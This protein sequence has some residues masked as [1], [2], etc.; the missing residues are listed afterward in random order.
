MWLIE[1][2]WRLIFKAIA[3]VSQPGDSDPFLRDPYEVWSRNESYNEDIPEARVL[4]NKCNFRGHYKNSFA[5][6]W[7]TRNIE[8]VLNTENRW[9]AIKAT[10]YYNRVKTLLSKRVKLNSFKEFN[11]RQLVFELSSIQLLE[12]EEFRTYGVV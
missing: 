11:E 5:L 10:L 9:C 1:P 7:K 4:H 6:D 12:I 8:Q 3:G 2:E